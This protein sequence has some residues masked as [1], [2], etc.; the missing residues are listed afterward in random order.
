MQYINTKKLNINNLQKDGDAKKEYILL[1]ALADVNIANY[2]IIDKTFDQ[3]NKTSNVH[4]HCYRFPKTD[5]KK[6]EFIALFTKKGTYSKSTLT[7][8]T[9]PLHCFFWGSDAPFWN[10]DS[11]EQAE[12]LKVTT[13]DTRTV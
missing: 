8:K 13:I 2:A 9:T 5:I 1:E 7:D 12:L 11:T 3:D 10:D 6:G 4:R